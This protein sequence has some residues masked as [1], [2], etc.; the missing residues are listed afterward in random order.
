MVLISAMTNMNFYRLLF[1][2]LLPIEIFG[3]CVLF[4][5]SQLALG[6]EAYYID[7]RKEGGT[8]QDGV[9]FG[10][11]GKVD[12]ILPCAFYLGAEGAFATG[13]SKGHTGGG[14]SIRSRMSD[15]QYEGRIGYTFPWT[16]GVCGTITPYFVYG[17]YVGMND[18]LDPSPI[19]L[20]YRNSY[21]YGGGG[22][23]TKF[24][25]G[26]CLTA[27]F[28]WSITTSLNPHS[29]ITEDPIEDD[30]TLIMEE[31]VQ[32]AFEVPVQYK[33]CM[34]GGIFEVGITPFIRLRHYGG[35]ENF[36]TDFFTTKFYI[37]GSRLDLSY[38]F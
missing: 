6:P 24:E 8:R 10:I 12:R 4:K 29:T 37:Y 23:I 7:R 2:L 28:Q 36:P 3:S 19:T 38:G 31:K 1:L 26:S 14:A 27:G 22:M 34:C 30:Q 13:I 11:R 9:L 16:F 32:Y 17:Q 15:Y 25:I 33:R 35:R 21:R 5:G 20:R 18:F